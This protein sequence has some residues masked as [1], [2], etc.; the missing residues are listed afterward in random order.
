MEFNSIMPLGRRKRPPLF[1]VYS[2]NFPRREIL[3]VAVSG[4]YYVPGEEGELYAERA[5]QD[6]G[7]QHRAGWGVSPICLLR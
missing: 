6:L 5:S 2:L 1:P 4:Q 7:Q 3:R